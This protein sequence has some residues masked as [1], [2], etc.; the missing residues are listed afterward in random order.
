[1]SIQR[2]THSFIV[3]VWL[4]HAG[5]TR[6]APAW[7]GRVTHVPSGQ[8]RSFTELSEIAA[9]IAPYLERAGAPVTR[10]GMLRRW[11]G[12]WQA[13]LRRLWRE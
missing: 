11:C 6:A 2:D 1:M 8:V 12:A 10:R 3:K 9:F 4:E 13:R 5:S 7:R